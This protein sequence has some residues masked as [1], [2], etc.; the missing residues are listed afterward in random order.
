[1]KEIKLEKPVARPE[2]KKDDSV[3]LSTEEQ[4]KALDEE[5]TELP[6]EEPEMV[7]QPVEEEE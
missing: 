1:V 5:V 7:E 2:K 3:P 4:E 6:L